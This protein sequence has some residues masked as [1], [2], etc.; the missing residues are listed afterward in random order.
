MQQMDFIAR[1]KAAKK[2]R[3]YTVSELAKKSGIPSGT[4]GK[5]LANVTAEPKLSTVLALASALSCSPAYLIGCSDTI[6]NSPLTDAE[7][8]LLKKYRMLD[9]HGKDIADCIISKE[10]DR[11]LIST[12]AQIIGSST[13]KT[14]KITKTA[15]YSSSARVLSSPAR[16]GI[17]TLRLFDLPVSAGFGTLLESSDYT[18]IRVKTGTAADKAD[19]ALRISGNSM[20]PQYSDGDTLLIHEQPAVDVGQLGIFIA[21]DCGYFKKYGGDRLISLNPDYDDIP[22][23][24]FSD[25]RCAGAVLGRIKKK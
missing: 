4:L 15:K 8:L 10:Y 18:E 23:S 12:D 11:I 5:L 24:R 3:G 22:L 19:F 20:E 2:E 21:D 9:F 25:V 6:D 16:T 14:A 1:V 7:T 13:A 17:R